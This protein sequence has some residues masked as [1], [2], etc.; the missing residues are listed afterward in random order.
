MKYGIQ[1]KQPELKKESYIKQWH[2]K[3][4]AK[5][6]ISCEKY[7]KNINLYDKVENFSKKKSKK[8]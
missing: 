8:K 3:S 7:A 4:S 1:P 2:N 5:S 6:S